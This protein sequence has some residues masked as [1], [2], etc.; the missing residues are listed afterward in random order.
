MSSVTT[1]SDQRPS[2]LFAP[3]TPGSSPTLLPATRS[4]FQKEHSTTDD[5]RSFIS[6]SSNEDP[7]SLSLASSNPSLGVPTSFEWDNHIENEPLSTPLLTPELSS[8]VPTS[9]YQPTRTD[10]TSLTFFDKFAQDAK[11]NLEIRRK[12]LVDELLK[13]EDDPLFFLHNGIEKK[14]EEHEEIRSEIFDSDKEPISDPE[15]QTSPPSLPPPLDTVLHDLD[16][17]YFSSRRL[18]NTHND[19]DKT[20]S[21]QRLSSS[22][23]T[24]SPSQPSPPTLAPP[25]MDS[26][27]SSDLQTL[28]DEP[29]T[30]NDIAPSLSSSSTFSARWMSNLL[31]T[32]SG[33]GQQ[34]HGQA[35]TSTL[36]SILGVNAD[37]STSS[38]HPPLGTSPQ[39][40]ASTVSAIHRRNSS[41][42]PI[43]HHQIPHQHPHASHTLPRSIIIKH[44]ASPFGTHSYIPPSGAP[45]F[46]GESYDWDKGFSNE[47]EREIVQGRSRVTGN[48][49][50]ESSSV[51]DKERILETEMQAQ[52]TR[53]DIGIGAFMERKTGNLDMKGRRASTSPV[54]SQNLANLVCNKHFFLIKK[55]VLHCSI[56]CLVTCISPCP[57]S[58]SSILDSNL[59][60]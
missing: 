40:A 39:S 5:H 38:S 52:Y 2:S 25:I 9:S 34:Q 12:G 37:A 29:S 33:A 41:S 46:R 20:S 13:C 45:G 22:F 18:I 27:M 19:N 58:S 28:S 3:S 48:G 1:M 44:T 59:F 11:R 16:H 55:K 26:D 47:L 57:L 15:L 32:N 30:R 31:K 21:E 14:D 56:Q 24:Q 23:H 10:N 43:R 50:E 60:T 6:V 49:N 51:D 42:L 36:E 53:A 35:V 7:L 17:D 4:R 8:I 54:L